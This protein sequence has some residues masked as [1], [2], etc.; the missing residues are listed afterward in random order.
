[1]IVLPC[2]LLAKILSATCFDRFASATSYGLMVCAPNTSDQ[3]PNHS[4][5]LAGANSLPTL[6]SPFL[7][8]PLQ[9][10]KT[11]HAN[12]FGYLICIKSYGSRQVH[13]VLNL[14]VSLDPGHFQEIARVQSSALLRLRYL[15]TKRDCGSLLFPR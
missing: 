15:C 2:L 6:L 9:H 5:N 13:Y 1:M 7:I 3:R 8:C 14:R 12:D 11:S 10:S 4:C